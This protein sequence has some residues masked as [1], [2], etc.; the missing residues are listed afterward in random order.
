MPCPA[1]RTAGGRR[2]AVDGDRRRHDLGWRL[3]VP[4]L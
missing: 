4:T 3:G 1:D 2:S